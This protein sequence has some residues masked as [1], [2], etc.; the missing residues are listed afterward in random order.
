MCRGVGTLVGPIESSA[1]YEDECAT[2][3]DERA[4]EEERRCAEEEEGERERGDSS[5]SS[6]DEEEAAAAA[7][8]EQR[9][10]TAYPNPTTT[11]AVP[12][13]TSKRKQRAPVHNSQE[14]FDG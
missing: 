2:E 12:T 8:F 10:Q 13:R 1:E 14:G 3:D 9:L 5:S 11:P 6:E 4:E 7:V